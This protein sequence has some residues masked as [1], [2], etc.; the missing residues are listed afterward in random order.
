M[1]RLTLRREALTPLSDDA[2][3]DVAGAALPTTVMRTFPVTDCVFSLHCSLGC[4]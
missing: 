1:R 2:L 3:A 4:P